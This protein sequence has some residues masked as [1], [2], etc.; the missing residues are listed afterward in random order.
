[1]SGTGCTDA[2]LAQLKELVS[3][4]DALL[5]CQGPDVAKLGV[6]RAVLK[7]RGTRASCELPLLLRAA[8]VRGPPPACR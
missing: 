3:S 7:V 4:E 5:I 8:R 2:Q 6:D 1:M